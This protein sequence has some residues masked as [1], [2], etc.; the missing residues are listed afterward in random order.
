[1]ATNPLPIVIPCHRVVARDGSL[2]GYGGG[3]EMK[4]RLLEMEGVEVSGS[5]PTARIVK[6][7][8]VKDKPGTISDER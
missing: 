7:S 1:M 8:Q 6:F 3:L 2:H 4:K 5:G